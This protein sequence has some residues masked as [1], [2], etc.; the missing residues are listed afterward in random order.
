MIAFLVIVFITL[1]AGALTLFG[2][3]HALVG[4]HQEREL[5][6][7]DARGLFS[8]PLPGNE[9]AGGGGE[10]SINASTGRAELIE[11]A[12]KGDTGALSEAHSTGDAGLYRETLDALIRHASGSQESMA[13]LVSHIA[14]GDELRANTELAEKALANW[15]SAPDRRST[16]E[17]LHVAA[18]SDDAAAYQKA[19]EEVLASW[20][21][22]RLAGILAEELLALIESE[23]WV[24]ASDARLGGAGFALKRM[25][26]DVRRKLAAAT[27]AR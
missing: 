13:A 20:Q 24:L 22:G 12:R 18:L 7:P 26:A 4:K 16:I 14:K 25:L 15:K 9:A 27:P 5:P 3:W 21:G 23:Y 1:A 17:A 2:L 10:K 8:D 6:P 19:V 11:R